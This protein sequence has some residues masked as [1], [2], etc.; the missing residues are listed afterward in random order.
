MLNRIIER[1]NKI[2]PLSET[3]IKIV[4]AALRLFLEKGFSATTHRQV[5]EKSGVGLGT[6][7]YHFR[8]KE[9][10]LRILVEELM[11]Y[12]L[13]FIEYQ[14]ESTE[15]RLFSYAAEIAVQIALCE[16][17]KRAWDLYYNAYAH[18]PTFT[19]IKDW[20]SKKNYELLGA[21]TPR[22]RESDYR[23][24]ENITSGI[25]LAALSSPC[26]RYFTL[27]DKIKL[28]LDSMMKIYDIPEDMRKGTIEKVLALDCKKIA[29]DLFDKFVARLDGDRQNK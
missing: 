14:V 26:D 17:D 24:I 25:E 16:S 1:H 7:T 28:T 19:Y 3:E 4:T 22:L 13:D 5:A 15:D 11:D 8:A 6:L 12:H 21:L 20:A 2:S 29:M 10:M 18:V 23:N 9:D 27:E